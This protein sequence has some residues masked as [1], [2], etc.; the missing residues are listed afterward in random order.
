MV[1]IDDYTG[2]IKLFIEF[3]KNPLK[4]SRKDLASNGDSRMTQPTPAPALNLAVD[5]VFKSHIS[6]YRSLFPREAVT[7]A[8]TSFIKLDPG[9]RVK[10]QPWGVHVVGGWESGGYI[11]PLGLGEGRNAHL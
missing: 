2:V 5:E 3:E 6:I 10:K 9:T 7:G 4:C 1:K 11:R 8:L